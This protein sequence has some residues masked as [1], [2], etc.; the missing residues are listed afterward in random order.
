MKN[1]TKSKIVIEMNHI[2]HANAIFEFLKT[3]KYQADMGGDLDLWTC[4]I[5]GKFNIGHD[6]VIK[7]IQHIIFKDQ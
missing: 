1:K 6:V 3:V 2:D 4:P 5:K 7:K